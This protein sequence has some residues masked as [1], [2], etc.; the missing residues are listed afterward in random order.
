MPDNM[1]RFWRFLLRRSIPP[2]ALSSLRFAVAGLG[3]SNYTD[4]FNFAAKKLHRRLENLSASPLLDVALADDQDKLGLTSHLD[5]A[6]I[7]L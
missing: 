2:D 6:L 7:L 5:L 4:T 3:D 1:K